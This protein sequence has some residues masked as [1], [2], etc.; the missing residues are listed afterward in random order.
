MPQE[1][2][3]FILSDLADKLYESFID[4]DAQFGGRFDEFAAELSCKIKTLWSEKVVN[5]A[6][7][8]ID[9]IPYPAR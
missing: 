5:S 7:F 8:D 3:L 2:H 1:A 9:R 4:V 6:R